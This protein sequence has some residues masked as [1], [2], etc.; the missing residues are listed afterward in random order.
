MIFEKI[1]S[2]GLMKDGGKY[3]LSATE[4]DLVMSTNQ[5]TNGR[6][7]VETTF[8][9]DKI[10]TT[11]VCDEAILVINKGTGTYANYF[12]IFDPAYGDNGGYL[13][14]YKNN[15]TTYYVSSTPTSD[16]FYWSISFSNNHVVLENKTY[17]GYYLEY[18]ASS[19]AN[20]FRL[21]AGTQTKI[22]LYELTSDIPSVTY[23][24]SITA[25]NVTVGEGST[26]T[27][28]GSYEP[29]N[30]TVSITATLGSDIA[31]LGEIT[32]SSG[33]FTVSITG[34]TS[35]STTLTLS[36]PSSATTTTSATPTLTVSSYTATH[37]LV[38]ASSSL[39]NGS[40]VV[41][42]SQYNP[43]TE[44]EKYA[45]S[46]AAHTGG[47]YVPVVSTAYNSTK[48][49]LAA[50]V[51]TKEYTM[52]CI[53]SINGYWVLSDG[54]YFLSAPASAGNKL[55]R[56]NQLSDRCYFLIE[57]NTTGIVV[58]SYYAQEQHWQYQGEDV[59]YT[60]QYNYNSGT[61]SRF[62]LYRAESQ[63]VSSLYLSNQSLNRVQGFVDAFMHFGNVPHN[64]LDPDTG[65]C[66]DSGYGYFT[67]AL[68]A[69]NQLTPSEQED[70]CTESEYANAYDRF[71]DWASAN[72]YS[73][74]GYTLEQD[75]RLGLSIFGADNQISITVIVIIAAISVTSI[76]ALLVLKKRKEQF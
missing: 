13:E 26:I 66:K 68:N 8:I 10:H 37:T 70:F 14:Y 42:G 29:A 27:Y 75:A 73:F 74:N 20:Y 41:F 62:A 76:G 1:D 55:Q 7:S 12:T 11:S 24:S 59:D 63:T 50:A 67:A 23:L 49:T 3:I 28:S 51:S 53:D 71:S 17:S 46:G 34:T 22:D 25:A 43:E 30:A 64:P 58:K 40:K 9:D 65:H 38:T 45:I 18:N 61:N 69:Y 33:T 52:W 16:A 57:D 15:L 19:S 47:D 44:S 72:G 35:G 4:T 31:T 2:A 32:M 5:L 21:Y 48:T 36:G 60:I 39:D 56:T 6:T 54:G